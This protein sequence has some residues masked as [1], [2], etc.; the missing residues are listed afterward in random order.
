M[1]IP[2]LQN[3]YI[4]ASFDEER[5][6]IRVVYSEE[7]PIEVPVLFYRWLE[8]LVE[9]VDIKTVRGG[10]FDLRKT[11]NIH[12]QILGRTSKESRAAN[13]K[14]DMSHV[15]IAFIVETLYQSEVAR[16]LIHL[17][18]QPE[19]RHIVKSEEEALRFIDE[20]NKTHVPEDDQNLS[21]AGT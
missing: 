12:P 10:T 5:H 6:L 2:P 7:L 14:T 4:R 19:R 16:I 13:R 17:T 21:S 18:P 20:W 11:K 3:E 9:A 8:S 15:P 1:N